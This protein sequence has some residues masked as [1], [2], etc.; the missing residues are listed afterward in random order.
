MRFGEINN[1]YI[2][3][4]AK[5]LYG[6]NDVNKIVKS[7]IAETPKN[8]RYYTAHLGCVNMHLMKS[9]IKNILVYLKKHP[10]L[11]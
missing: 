9:V 6:T 4:R 7:I 8:G 1:K 3:E 2:A 10:V 11:V 5:A